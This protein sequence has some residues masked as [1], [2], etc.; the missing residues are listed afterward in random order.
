[1]KLF[2][3]FALLIAGLSAGIPPAMANAPAPGE[4]AK[5]ASAKKATAARKDAQDDDQPDVTGLKAT[6]FNC[7]LGNKITIYS[8]AANDQQIALQWDKRMH[9]MHRVGTTTGAHRFENAQNGLVWI[10]IPAKGMLLDSKKGKQLAN[11]C[12]SPEQAAHK[13]AEG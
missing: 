8:D 4:T 10:G 9:R 1:M 6:A 11:E 7:E 13:V 2:T 5:K 12:K 3:A